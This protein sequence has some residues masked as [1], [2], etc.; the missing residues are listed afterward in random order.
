MTIPNFSK[1]FIYQ[2]PLVSISINK[3][4][5]E[6]GIPVPNALLCLNIKIF[7]YLK[8][9]TVFNNITVL[10]KSEEIIFGFFDL[11]NNNRSSSNEPRLILREIGPKFKCLAFRP[12][13]SLKYYQKVEN[14]RIVF[15]QNE[16]NS[17]I[18]DFQQM[19]QKEQFGFV[20]VTYDSV[21]GTY[22]ERES[23]KIRPNHLTA[24]TLDPTEI[25]NVRGNSHWYKNFPD[26]FKEDPNI[27]EPFTLIEVWIYPINSLV[28]QYMEKNEFTWIDLFTGIGGLF[29]YA[30]GLWILL[31]GPGSFKSWGIMQ[32]YIL[33]TAPNANKRRREKI[34][35][36]PILSIQT[37]SM[38][39]YSLSDNL[40]VIH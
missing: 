37:F 1:V 17:K 18:D 5:S 31:F 22:Q 11:E 13:G 40:R 33:K 24:I 2:D 15:Y 7:P 4:K 9:I 10:D 16:Y 30:S 19:W 28:T 23:V 36:S 8:N 6:T 14:V 3:N 34:Q 35:D 39:L 32:Q 21:N 38:N 20:W 12:D 26:N 25:I 29:T 27:K